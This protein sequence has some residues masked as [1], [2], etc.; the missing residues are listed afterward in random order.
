[1]NYW[2]I[3]RQLQY[4]LRLQAWTGSSTLVFNSDSILIVAGENDLEAIE[5][6][7]ILPACLIIP[8]DG[9]TD[10][11]GG[12]QP[13]LISRQVSFVIVTRN[14]N[15]ERGT[16][17]II[18]AARE[19]VTDSRGRGVLEIEREVFNA[20]EKLAAESGII[21]TVRMTGAPATRKDPEDNSYA[22]Q[23]FTGEVFCSADPYFPPARRL[24]A[25]IR[26]GEVSLTWTNPATRYDTYRPRLIRKAGSVAPT[27][28]SDG[29]ELV[30]VGM[31]TSKV[32]SLLASGTYSYSLFMSYDDFSATPATDRQT[33]E[34]VSVTGVVVP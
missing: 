25:T 5:S 21:I 17:A 3:L 1:M 24:A 16:G 23:D 22:F 7:L 2:Q 13:D 20:V 18:G 6:R 28:T 11:E 31:A 34:A 14:E 32:D 26:T 10:P 4:L 29:T 15:D 12:D 30:L 33:S 9:T 27:S 19:S 8:G